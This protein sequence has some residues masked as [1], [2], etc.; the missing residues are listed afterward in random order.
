MKAVLSTNAKEFTNDICE[1]I[2]L[3]TGPDSIVSGTVANPPDEPTG[4]VILHEYA[5]VHHAF[6]NIVHIRITDAKGT[7]IRSVRHR[8]VE[9]YGAEGGALAFKRF[10]KRAMKNAVYVCMQKAFPMR[11]PWGSLTGIRP[12]RLVYEM[13]ARGLD[14]EG[15]AS[16]LEREFFLEHAKARLLIETVENQKDVLAAQTSR[17]IDVY[18]GIPFCV[19]R[20]V[21]C[22]F[23]AYAL[24]QHSSA[25]PAYLSALHLEMESAGKCSIDGWKPRSLYIGG[26]TPTSLTANELASVIEHALRVF[27][28]FIEITVEAGRPDTLDEEKL[29]ML[30]GLGVHRISIN[31]QTMN[32][33]TLEA[34]GRRHSPEDMVRAYEAARAVGFECINTDLILG[35]P[36]EGVR[37]AVYTLEKILGMRPE[38][39]TVH[40]LAL[41][42]ASVLM[43]KN[44]SYALP[45]ATAVSEMVDLSRQIA[46]DC[47]YVPY[48]LYRQK[49]MTG[50]FENVGYCQKGKPC[51]YNIDIMEE[52]TS[53]LALGA[54]AISKRIYHAETRIERLPNPKSLEHYIERIA[55]HIAKKEAF[56]R[57]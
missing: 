46:S 8:S 57:V 23:P 39:V 48:Y 17:D 40:T 25:V 49:Y 35:L 9:P 43:E 2:R 7:V 3:F 44:G 14:S 37:D 30:R 10:C 28:G 11:L 22:S 15:A 31:P 5:Y 16:A 56:F 19:S 21:Y 1:V 36:G 41:K 52:T 38:N 27:G 34:I 13:Y 29:Q 51:V 53:N 24:G 20:C 12:T 50:N 6:E 47:G 45:P 42:R 18:I 4:T 54:G 26:G 32:A 55:E 33:R